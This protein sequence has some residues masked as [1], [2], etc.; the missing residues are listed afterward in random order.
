ME[1]AIYKKTTRIRLI[2]LKRMTLTLNKSQYLHAKIRSKNQVRA[3]RKILLTISGYSTSVSF[4]RSQVLHIAGKSLTVL[5][6]EIHSTLNRPIRIF[7]GI[8]TSVMLL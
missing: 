7:M 2:I 8:F 6:I 3:V 5:S 1:E 4:V